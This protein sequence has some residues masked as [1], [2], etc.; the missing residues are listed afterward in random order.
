MTFMTEER[1][2]SGS[3]S[4]PALVVARARARAHGE[5]RIGGEA[6][7]VAP[8]AR[9]AISPASAPAR[10]RL[11]WCRRLHIAPSDPGSAR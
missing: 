9:R 7:A 2:G 1:K 3:A 5:A 4:R 11:A 6:R 10:P 8:D